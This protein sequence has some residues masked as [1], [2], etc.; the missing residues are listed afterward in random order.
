[1]ITAYL[2]NNCTSCKKTERMLKD[3][4]VPFEKREYFNDRFTTD[5]LKRVLADAGLTPRDVLSKRSRA[6]KARALDEDQLSDE[7]LIAVMVEEPTLLRRPLVVS[8]EDTVIGH[9][10][11]QLSKLIVNEAQD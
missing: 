6:Y 1:M 3:A 2:Y 10:A 8:D 4:N 11:N 5:E 7:E 9:N